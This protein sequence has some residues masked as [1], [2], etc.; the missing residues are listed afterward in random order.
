MEEITEVESILHRHPHRSSHTSLFFKIEVS[1]VKTSG[2]IASTPLMVSL[3][4]SDLLQVHR[5]VI[6]L[7]SRVLTFT[8]PSQHRGRVSTNI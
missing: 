5:A 8:D 4:P 1:S 3:F 2:L 6:L 7:V